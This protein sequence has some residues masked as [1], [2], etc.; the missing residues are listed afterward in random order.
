MAEAEGVQA[1]ARQR[2]R[3]STLDRYRAYVKAI[4]G[5]GKLRRYF[6]SKV[7]PGYVAESRGRRRGDC[8]RCG[9][10]CAI[11]FRCPMLK[12]GNHCSVYRKR[13]EQCSHF[14][15][16]ARDLR[17]LEHVCGYHFVHEDD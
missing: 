9:S 8:Q 3:R 12:D 2:P 11:M 14:P 16:D 13:P 7:R 5:W 10:C 17:Y 6:L 15:I 1:G 4:Q